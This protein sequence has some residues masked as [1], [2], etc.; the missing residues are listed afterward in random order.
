MG[1][2]IPHSRK[3]LYKSFSSMSKQ[4]SKTTGKTAFQEGRRST[5]VRDLAPHSA[6]EESQKRIFYQV[7]I[8][9]HSQDSNGAKFPYIAGAR[10]VGGNSGE[11]DEQGY[12][13]QSKDEAKV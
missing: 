8:E 2:L 7:D 10:E 3:D 5:S 11:W 13:W 1:V 12:Q 6:S 4:I 9:L